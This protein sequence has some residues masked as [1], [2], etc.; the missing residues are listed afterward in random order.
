MSLLKIEGLTKSFGSLMAVLDVSLDVAEGELHAVI[1]PNGA[2]KTTAFNL[3]SGMLDPTRGS[4]QFAGHDIT[5]LSPNERVR[6]GI[7]RTFQITEIFPELTVVENLRISVE[8]A[9]GYRMRPWLSRAQTAQ[10][11]ERVE[12]LAQRVGL[13]AKGG[14]LVGELSHGD[15]R[16]VEIGL[17]LAL[18]PK[19]LLLDEP[20]AGMGDQETE[21]ITA[22]MHRLHREE[23]LTIV[24]IE[25]DMPLV[26]KVADRITVLAQGQVLAGGTPAEI[27]SN[28]AVQAAYLGQA[29]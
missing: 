24:L 18:R 2:G 25:H 3:I 17:A 15:Q 11:K 5:R 23:K 29:E 16:A 6:K 21:D 14:R 9:A 4:I 28:A 8:V 12:Q 22:L 10:V 20:T 19:L 13:T 7:A 27:A 1:G 26:F